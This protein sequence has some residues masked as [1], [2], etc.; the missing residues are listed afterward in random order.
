MIAELKRC[1][2]LKDGIICTIFYTLLRFVPS[3]WRNEKWGLDQNRVTTGE[4]I[5][6][7]VCKTPTCTTDIGLVRVDRGIQ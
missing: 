7:H 4:V 3:F 6:L 1:C 5:L 2:S